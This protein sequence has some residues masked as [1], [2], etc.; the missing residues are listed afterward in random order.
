MWPL[1]FMAAG[2]R[3]RGRNGH[4]MGLPPPIRAAQVYA[5]ADVSSLP[6]RP[7]VFSL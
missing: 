2:W 3:G 5:G 4:V 7:G 1:L 6:F